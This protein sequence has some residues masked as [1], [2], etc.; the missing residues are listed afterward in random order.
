M[1]DCVFCDIVAG[2]APAQYVRRWADATAFVP[3]D[4]V[5]DGHVLIV[6]NEHVRDAVE[7]PAVTAAALLRAAELAAEHEA[8]NILTSIGSAATQ[9]IFHLHW[10]VIRRAPGDQLMVPWGTTGD[11]HNPH[12]CRV[13]E[14][15]RAA[16]RE[17]AYELTAMADRHAAVDLYGLTADEALLRH[18]IAKI[19]T[20]IGD[21]VEPPD[22]TALRVRGW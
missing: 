3:L 19:R 10:H 8:S 17:A 4:P 2:A 12:W 20:A 7:R 18:A 21:V 14:D 15:Q 9:S 5:V 1:A 6:P 13:A 16:V 22:E 11:P